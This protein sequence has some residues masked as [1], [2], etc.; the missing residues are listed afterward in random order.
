MNNKKLLYI[1]LGL[2][3]VYVLTQLFNS[4]KERSFDSQFLKLDTALV[5]KIV[6]HSASDD[7]KE[8][9]LEK[10]NGDWWASQGGKKVQAETGSVDGI[11]K[12]LSLINVKTILTESKVRHKEYEIE[13]EKGSRVEVYAGTKKLADFFVGKFGFNPQGNSMVSYLRKAG[14]NKV[15]GVDGFQSMT[16]NQQFS[17]FRNKTITKLNTTD[18]SSVSI[19]SN[20]TAHSLSKQGSTWSLDQKPVADSNAVQNYLNGL[21]ALSGSDLIDQFQPAAPLHTAQIDANTKI[22]INIYASGDSLKPF[23]IHSSANKEV[24]FKED[25]NG[26]FNSLIKGIGDLAKPKK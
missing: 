16:F 15:F 21:Q 13:D 19:Q 18:I 23:I 26:V 24:Y 8:L 1:L 25:S 14:E 9:I 4:K 3:I 5:N 2:G 6:L 7:H 10:S 11:I 22:D 12:E 17:N 20:G